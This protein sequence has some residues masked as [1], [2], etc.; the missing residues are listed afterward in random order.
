M[1]LKLTLLLVFS[2]PL[3]LESRPQPVTTPGTKG[4]PLSP[5]RDQV[6]PEAE[7]IAPSV[8]KS[9]EPVEGLW[10]SPKLM[11]L[12][13][14]R[15]ADEAAGQYKLDESQKLKVQDALVDRWGSFLEENRTTL[16]PLTNEFLEM[17][18]GLAPPDTKQVQEWSARALPAFERVREEFRAT[19]NEFREV[20]T[21]LQR[22]KFEI[23]SIKAAAGLEIANQKLKQWS[24]GDIDPQEMWE[25]LPSMRKDRRRRGEEGGPDEGAS[26]NNARALVASKGEPLDPVS[27]E[28]SAWEQY[29][30]EFIETHGLNEGQRTAALSC[31]KELTERAS[32]HRDKNRSEIKELE[33]RIASH[34]GSQEDLEGIKVKLVELYGPID[35]MFK[36][37]RARLDAIPTAE[38]RARAEDTAESSR[39][40]S[41]SAAPDR[42]LPTSGSAI[43]PK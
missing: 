21:P 29:V 3:Q 9:P 17:R 19:Q 12:L 8:A 40:K 31:L 4:E 25:P 18:L 35:E 30:K 42:S 5:L 43:D 24:R 14:S 33:Q 20:L 37:L 38:Q 22:A 32:A 23:E 1:L 2:A 34:S 26:P 36:E 16:Q 39:K 11:K 10:P 13:L 6:E 41:K 7:E 28:L 27:A 15:W